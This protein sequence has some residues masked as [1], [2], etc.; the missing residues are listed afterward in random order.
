MAKPDH[1]KQSFRAYLKAIGDDAEAAR[2]LGVSVRR[3][4]SWRWR[5]RMPRTRDI[6]ELIR[7]SR[8]A[9]T[10]ASFFA[11]DDSAAAAAQFHLPRKPRGKSRKAEET[12]GATNAE[13]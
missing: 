5:E 2:L 6:P 8:G 12:D 9:L 13:L 3:V 11:A 4:R 1:P 7:R 10:A